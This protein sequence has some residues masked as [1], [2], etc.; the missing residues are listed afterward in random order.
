MPFP[1]FLKIGLYILGSFAI[2]AGGALTWAY[3]YRDDVF[4]YLLK[5]ANAHIRG[6][7]TAR[8]LDF[9]PFAGGFGLSFTLFDIHLRDSAYAIHHKELL[10]LER[11]TVHIDLRQLLRKQL[12]INSVTVDKGK[13]SVFVDKNGYS[14]LQAIAPKDSS[15][16][17]D[18]TT[19]TEGSLGKELLKS[20]RQVKMK[21]M[22][23][24][25]QDSLKGKEIHFCLE[26]ITNDLERTDTCLWVHLRGKTQFHQLTFN[27]NR[28]GFL[29]NKTTELDLHL[30]YDLHRRVGI[31]PSEVLVE[32]DKFRLR[33]SFDF[34]DEGRVQLFVTT[35]TIAAPRA[36]SIL[37]R[38]LAKRIAKHKVLPVVKAEVSVDGPLRTGAD[39]HIEVEVQTQT[40]LYKS[41]IGPLAQTLG[42]AHFTNRA[43]TSQPVS[44]K[45]SRLVAP[46][47]SGLLYGVIPMNLSFT[48]TDFD[49][50]FLHMEGN[51]KANVA[52]CKAL[53]DPNQ[54]QPKSGNV[55]VNFCYKGKI[56]PIFDP[57]TNRLNGKLDGNA[58]LEKVAFL[59]TPQQIDIQRVDGFVRFAEDKAD[60]TYLHVYHQKN[61]VRV[62][63]NVTGLTPY[64]FGTTASVK[65]NVSI[66]APD[67]GLDWIR[68]Y[69][70]TPQKTTKKQLTD[71][72]S[73]FIQ[74]LD[75][76]VHLAARRVHYR[77][78]EAQGV[79][80]RV[81]MTR[82]AI[83]C[84]D[85]KMHAFGG[86][87]RV[88][89]G[90]E[91][92]DLPTHR[93][94]AKGNV[95]KADVQKVFYAF[96]NFGQQTVSDQNLSGTLSTDFTYSTQLDKEFQLLPKTMKGQLSFH[97]ID[98]QLN[99][100]K[101]L[102]RIQK[103]LFKRRN[104]Q[105]IQFEGLKNDFVL[106]GQELS[107]NQMKVA[108][109][110]LTFFVGG[111]YSFGDKTDLLVHIPL[112]NLKRNPEEEELETLDGNNLLIRAVE[113]HGEIRLKYDMDWRRKA[114]RQNK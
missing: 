8:K 42:R 34:K 57:K 15:S 49:D 110:V 56:S 48:I 102:L 96:E 82:Q 77:K 103:V 78:F 99:H 91:Q 5:E 81:Y 21:E 44:N 27:L 74:N 58:K 19:S 35:D 7:V 62:S 101:P 84:E 104:F 46:H 69:R 47:V 39:P 16:T 88:T 113:E 13:L 4:Q 67:L 86:D 63:G 33:G 114:R 95:A 12:Q 109:S 23:V 60:L 20:L 66:F 38:R 2:L 70:P 92:F 87:F 6:K 1:K 100:F 32:Q 9:T 89:G 107:M 61:Q 72:T 93:L 59:Y 111:T 25:L 68:N 94:Y 71:I 45:N 80:G 65:A 75:L 51:T 112:N 41:A 105:K 31:S 11:L 53:F 79:S 22:E 24:H 36:L 90:I 106:Q 10:A 85:V 55:V 3:Q 97:L 37:P 52:R 64:A 14:N 50:P 30:S 98:G 108:S 76:K 83:R 18:T 43:D 73:K 40:F 26:K 17:Q 29:E 28:G 54:V